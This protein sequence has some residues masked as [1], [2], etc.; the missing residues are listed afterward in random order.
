MS[1]IRLK[2]PQFNFMKDQMLIKD[3]QV[4]QPHFLILTKHTCTNKH[5]AKL[6]SRMSWFIQKPPKKVREPKCLKKKANQK[7][8]KET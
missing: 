3:W 2:G 5:I 4:N 1:A 8:K 7:K 6:C